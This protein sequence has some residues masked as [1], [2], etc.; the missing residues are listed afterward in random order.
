MYADGNGLNIR[1]DASGAKQ[2]ILRVAIGGER[3]M[4]GLGGYPSVSLSEARGRADET[5]RAIRQGR[6]PLAEKRHAIALLRKPGIPTFQ[7]LA[8][9]V[10]SQREP[11]WRGERHRA[12]WTQSLS[13][14]VNPVIGSMPMDMVSVDDVLSILKPIWITHHETAKRVRQWMGV[15]FNRAVANGLRQDNPAGPAVD[16]MLAPVRHE[17]EH[18][19]ALSYKD[20]TAA[21]PRVSEST[22]NIETRLAFE[23]IVLTACWAGEGRGGR[24]LISMRA[25]GRYQVLE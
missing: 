3:T 21:T 23:F 12:Q 13:K 15:A 8:E 14:Y 22:A 25:N 6:D 9:E 17:P 10:I 7:E 2:W 24:R 16:G 4:M 20:L 5:Q 1:V 19:A 11:S 18:H